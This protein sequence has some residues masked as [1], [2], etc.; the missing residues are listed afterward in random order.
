MGYLLFLFA[1]IIFIVLCLVVQRSLTTHGK[2]RAINEG[3]STD[4]LMDDK[5][6]SPYSA[7]KT[8][9]ENN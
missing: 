6:F 8:L 3:L 7:F 1:A 4:N 5:K 2:I 9:L